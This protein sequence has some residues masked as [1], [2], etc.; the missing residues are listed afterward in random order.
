MYFI[1]FRRWLLT[2]NLSFLPLV[3]IMWLWVCIIYKW[4]YSWVSRY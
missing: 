3:I 4:S 1:A 2:V